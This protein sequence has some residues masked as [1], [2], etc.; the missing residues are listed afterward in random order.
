[1]RNQTRNRITRWCLSL[2]ILVMAVAI[3]A[4][5]S[6]PPERTSNHRYDSDALPSESAPPRGGQTAAP[7]SGDAEWS[8]SGVDGMEKGEAAGKGFELKTDNK[9]LL[10]PSDDT[11]ASAPGS[12][13]VSEKRGLNEDDEDD[14]FGDH[15][16]DSTPSPATP[17]NSKR[18]T[19]LQ[20]N[21]RYRTNTA[22]QQGGAG[23]VSGNINLNTATA[24]QMKA[25]LP[26]PT[27]TSVAGP[28]QAPQIT[29]CG[30]QPP[31]LEDEVWV[32]VKPEVKPEQAPPAPRGDDYST[33]GSGVIVTE[34]PDDQGRKR[35]VPVPL[36]HTSVNASVAGYVGAVDVVQKFHN[37]YSS[38][39]EAVYVFPLPENAAVN[40]F[41]MTIGDR[42]I[43]GLI[44]ERKEAER[45]YEEAKHQ[46]YVASLLTQER[47]NIFTQKVANIEPGKRIDVNIRYYQTLRYEDGWYEFS[48]PM[49]VGPRYNP[50]GS[51]GAGV[52]AVPRNAKG[53]SGQTTEVSY[54]RPRE[55]SGHD[56]D[57]TL[58][59]EA[60]VK[61]EEAACTSHRTKIS[62]LRDSD[63]S[64]VTATIEPGDTIPNKDFVFR[65]RVAGDKIKANFLTHKDSRGGYFTMM[66]YPPADLG[67]LS[68]EPMEMVFVV[69]VSGSMMGEPIKR[70]K[71]AMRAALTSIDRRDTFQVITFAG[72]AQCMT[73][74]PIPATPEN[75][76]AA[77]AFVDQAQAGGGT[78]MLKGIRAAMQR[79]DGSDRRRL[80]A[81]MTDG[82]IGNE[83]EIIEAVGK[84]DRSIRFFSFG[85]GNSVNRYL[86]EGVARAGRGAVAYIGLNEDPAVA[87]T[88]YIQRVSHPALTDIKI[89]VP[90]ARVTDVFP[91][92]I[93]D[94]FVG[95]PIV[96]VGRLD[97]NPEGPARI[98]GRVGGEKFTT[99]VRRSDGTLIAAANISPPLAL[100][101][102]WARAKIADL[103]DYGPANAGDVNRFTDTVRQLAL[104]YSLMSDFTAFL[105]VDTAR[106]TEGTTGTTVQTPVPVP[107]GVS[108]DTTV[109]PRRSER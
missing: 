96:V 85:V 23:G 36:E 108:Y 105:A 14:M 21:L 67:S 80:V 84:A 78:E 22:G 107:D 46:G 68:R 73:A 65:W 63:G 17:A 79:I 12:K 48:F 69:D 4:C 9:P 41:I 90:G 91:R 95:R 11:G 70:V 30:V 24:E 5:E 98:T 82:Y 87:T 89:E 45:V 81:L 71:Q 34:I 2:M 26:I 75:I 66:V 93:P 104:D 86:I 54:L 56:I 97:G 88:A 77:M 103:A 94:L 10:R 25:A 13:I 7:G 76:D 83:K 59:V 28:H 74:E 8:K 102:L 100:P 3:V 64:R 55:R 16:H 40:E 43:R 72:Q 19:G 106:R 44:R 50:A 57:L 49:V 53:S 60:G 61:I 38:K 29:T 39:I 109:G 35:T 51:G 32:I 18:M 58:A 33:P 42:K 1:M 101:S 47:P 20:K 62:G 52:G 99:R 6:K 92:H 27:V 15:R 37:P 31:A